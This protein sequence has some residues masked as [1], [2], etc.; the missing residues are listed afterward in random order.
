[1]RKNIGIIAL[2]LF[3]VRVGSSG[4]ICQPPRR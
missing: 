2:A 1:M 4:A 3:F